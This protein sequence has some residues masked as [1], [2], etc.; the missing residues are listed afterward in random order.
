MFEY[1]DDGAMWDL[2]VSY[3]LSWLPKVEKELQFILRK[4]RIAAIIEK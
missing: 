4:T 1:S 3:G 2:F